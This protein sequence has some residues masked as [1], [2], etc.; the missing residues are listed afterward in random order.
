MF[1]AMISSD[2]TMFKEDHLIATG[3]SRHLHVWEGSEMQI[4]FKKI[5][6]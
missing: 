2:K 3:C 5:E 1:C 6:T 4:Q